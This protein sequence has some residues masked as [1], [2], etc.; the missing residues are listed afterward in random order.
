MF[1]DVE[2]FCDKVGTCQRRW[3]ND[4]GGLWCWGDFKKDNNTKFLKIKIEGEEELIRDVSKEEALKILA[5]GRDVWVLDEVTR[6][7]TPLLDAI[8]GKLI[9]EI[10]SIEPMA[11]EPIAENEPEEIIRNDE[12]YEESVETIEESQAEDET[13][14]EDKYKRKNGTPRKRIP[15][16]TGKIGALYKAN[17]SMAKIADEMGVTPGTIF[18]HLKKMGL[19]K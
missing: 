17:W 12:Q 15:L 7:F 19:K 14:L 11:E 9:G 13:D 4:D 16:D 3:A 5:S 18:Y 6:T 2:S 10:V 1:H 8:N